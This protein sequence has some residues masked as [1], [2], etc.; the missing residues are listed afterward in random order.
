MDEQ[1]FTDGDWLVSGV[2]MYGSEFGSIPTVD[3][4]FT[5]IPNNNL[6][7]HI[8]YQSM[9][10]N[11]RMMEATPKLYKLVLKRCTQCKLRGCETEC[12]TCEVGEVLRKIRGE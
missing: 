5:Y 4:T 3:F 2:S 9:Q 11:L 7:M 10:Q 12:D 6:V 8:N 1:L